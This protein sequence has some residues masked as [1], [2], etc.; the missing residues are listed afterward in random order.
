M[1]WKTWAIGFVMILVLM[2]AFGAF[3]NRQRA[4]IVIRWLA[5]GAKRIGKP[6]EVRWRGRMQSAGRL[7][8]SDIRPPYRSAELIFILEKRDNLPMWFY[9][10]LKGQRDELF[11][12]ADLRASPKLEIEAG[13]QGCNNVQHRL[14]QDAGYTKEESKPCDI[15]WRGEQNTTSIFRIQKFMKKYPNTNMRISLQKEEPHL[16]L[17]THLGKLLRQSPEEFFNDLRETIR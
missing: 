11:I 10:H 16:A 7:G 3:F 12:R 1:D 8:I 4:Q 9:H 14:A 2:Y 5:K 15:A 17:R 6:G 13:P